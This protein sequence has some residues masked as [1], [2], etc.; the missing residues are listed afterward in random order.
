MEG[1]GRCK[2]KKGIRRRKGRVGGPVTG[3]IACLCS[4]GGYST[5]KVTVVQCKNSDFL[6]ISV[7]HTLMRVENRSL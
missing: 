7:Q 3:M 4:R 2:R 5:G 6:K 1:K